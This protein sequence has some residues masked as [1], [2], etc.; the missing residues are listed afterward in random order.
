MT[1]NQRTARPTPNPTPSQQ[2]KD[3]GSGLQGSQRSGGN[4]ESDAQLYDFFLK[5]RSSEHAHSKDSAQSKDTSKDLSQSQDMS[6]SKGGHSMS[7]YTLL[8]ETLGSTGQAG[9]GRA[10]DAQTVNSD[11]AAPSPLTMAAVAAHDQRQQRSLQATGDPLSR[12]W[13]GEDKGNHSPK[14]VSLPYHSDPEVSRSTRVGAPK[15]P[16]LIHQWK[17]GVERH[18]DTESL[19]LADKSDAS[20]KQGNMSLEEASLAAS[21]KSQGE[22]AQ[23]KDHSEPTSTAPRLSEFPLS[24]Q[25]AQAGSSRHSLNDYFT[26]YPSARPVSNT[27]EEGWDVSSSPSEATITDAAV[28][29]STSRHSSQP[30]TKPSPQVW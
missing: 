26:K 28:T 11:L 8:K 9:S 17:V 3:G 6:H 14:N 29:P 15:P 1:G 2:G 16:S 20:L 27:H 4:K 21:R 13:G 25:D 12:S 23:G 10:G 24:E 5:P 22:A 7:E 30:A 19:K 18:S